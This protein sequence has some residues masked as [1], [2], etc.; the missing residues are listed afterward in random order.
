MFRYVERAERTNLPNQTS[1]NSPSPSS[2]GR[3]VPCLSLS[4][5]WS[6]L[7][8][9]GRTQLCVPTLFEAE[10]RD[11]RVFHVDLALPI[12]VVEALHHVLLT[13]LRDCMVESCY[14]EL[15]RRVRGVFLP[16]R[17]AYPVLLMQLLVCFSAGIELAHISRRIYS[18]G[19]KDAA[20]WWVPT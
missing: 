2:L 1:S 19:R 4:K 6:L 14:E 7:S 8:T 9:V 18:A 16:L 5:P 13:P 15:E 12:H 17:G 10:K 11:F 20:A 3:V